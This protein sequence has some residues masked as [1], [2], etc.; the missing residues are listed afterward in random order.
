MTNA[1]LLRG[2]KRARRVAALRGDKA[3]ACAVEW[4]HGQVTRQ[5][6]EAQR[7]AKRSGKRS[8]RG[9]EDAHPAKAGAGAAKYGCA[10]E[11]AWRGNCWYLG[12]RVSGF[13]LGVRRRPSRGHSGRVWRGTF[14]LLLEASA[15]SQLPTPGARSPPSPASSRTS[16]TQDRGAVRGRLP[17]ESATRQGRTRKPPKQ[18]RF[19]PEAPE[20]GS[21]QRRRQEWRQL[22]RFEPGTCRDDNE[23]QAALRPEGRHPCE[24]RRGT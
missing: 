18:G 20:E 1:W 4:G 21:L 17:R 15:R 2:E 9:E 7:D 14:A 22:G 16:K 6:T 13:R 10:G 24:K 3:M 12:F 23:P 19:Q 8:G 11:F 5:R